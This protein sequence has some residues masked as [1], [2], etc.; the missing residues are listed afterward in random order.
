MGIKDLFKSRDDEQLD[1]LKDLV[2][3]KLRVGYMLD[4]D[5]KTWQVTAYHKYDF[6]G[7]YETE[8]W[9]LTSGREKCYLERSQDDEVEWTLTKKIPIAA[10]EGNVKQ[11][12]IDHDDPPDQIVYKGKTYY[13]EESGPGYFL[14]NGVPPRKEFIYWEFIDE[15]EDQCISIEQWG[16]TDFEAAHGDYVEEYQFSNILPGG[17]T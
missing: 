17:N 3:S 14:E 10:I 16:E 15:E 13:L 1:P 4:H 11:S 9:E 2:L 12:I 7:R 6:G 5:M 8:E